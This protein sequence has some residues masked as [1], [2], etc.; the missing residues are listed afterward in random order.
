MGF[1]ERDYVK[2]KGGGVSV[3]NREPWWLHPPEAGQDEMSCT[4]TYLLTYSDG[5]FGVDH[6]RPSDDEIKNRRSCR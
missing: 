1:G 2:E 5:T 6:T 4:W 3:V